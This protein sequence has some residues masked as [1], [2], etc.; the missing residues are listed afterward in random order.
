M[1]VYEYVCSK[2]GS[3]FEALVMGDTEVAC[4]NCGSKEIKKQ[5]SAFAAHVGGADSSPDCSTGCG[6][7]FDRGACGSGMCGGG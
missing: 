5:F 6:G 7:G 4:N 2:C 1:P 3:F